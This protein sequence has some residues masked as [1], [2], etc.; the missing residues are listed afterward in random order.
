MIPVVMS[1]LAGESETTFVDDAAPEK[2]ER[3]MIARIVLRRRRQTFA[4]LM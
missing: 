4:C 1:Q 2:G 3:E